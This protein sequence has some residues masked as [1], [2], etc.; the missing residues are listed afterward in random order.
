VKK[1]FLYS[2]VILVFIIVVQSCVPPANN[3]PTAPNNP[4]PINGMIDVPL[5]L[6]LKWDASTDP[7]GDTIKYDVYLSSNPSNMVIKAL[8]CTTNSYEITQPLDYGTKYYWKV[9]AKD[10]KGGETEGT[11]WNFTTKTNNPPSIPSIPDPAD[12]AN[13]VSITPTLSW[14]KCTDPD[15]DI[16][17]YDVLFGEDGQSLTEM[18]TD[19]STNSFKITTPL[20]Y[21]TK[22]LWKV[23]AK[24]DNGGQSQGEIWIFTTGSELNTPPII[25]NN[26]TPMDKAGNVGIVPVISWNSTDPDGDTLTYDI[27]FGTDP[28]PTLVQSNY[29]DTKYNPGVLSYNTTYYWKIVAK[30]G[31]GGVTEGS[32][33]S[34]R[35]ILKSNTPPA[36]PS[37]PTPAHGKTGLDI[38]TIFS[39]KCSDPDGD[40]LIYDIYFGTSSTPTLVKSDYIDTKYYPGE[41][42]YSTRYYWKIVAKDGKGGETSSPVWSF[43]TMAKPNTP[44]QK[45]NNPTPADKA[46]DTSITPTLSWQCSD[47]DGDGLTYDIYF[48]S[49][50]TLSTAVKVGHTSTSY[51]P[52]TLEYSTTYYWKIVAKDG[53][54]G[55]KEGD[56]WSFTTIAKPNTP[57]TKPSVLSP[58]NGENGVSVTQ[59]LSWTSSDADGDSL[60]YDVYFGTSATPT[61]VSSNQEDATYAPTKMSYNTTYYWKVIAIDGKGGIT[62][63]DVW[64]FKT[65]P[66]PNTP[67]AIPSNQKPA[68]GEINV[69]TNPTLSWQCSDPD[70]D[71]ITYDVYFGTSATLAAPV[72]VGQS[73]AT[74]TPNVLNYS[75]RYYWKIVAKDGKGGETSGAVWSFV[76]MAKPNTPPQVPNNPTPADNATDTS[77]TPTLSWVCSDVDGDTLMYDIYFGKNPSSL[78]RVKQDQT[79]ATYN[80]GVLDYNKTYYWKIVAKD[81]KG[82]EVPSS[83]WNFTTIPEPNTAPTKPRNPVPANG[84][85]DIDIKSPT[86]SWLCNDPDGDTLTYDIYFGTDPNPAIKVNN[87]E[88]TTYNPGALSYNTTYYWKVVARDRKGGI[89]EG[90][91]W[92]FKTG[93]EPNTA[94]A[95]PS[96]PNPADNANGTGITPTLSW[97]SSDPDGDGL[98]YDVYFGT[99]PDPDSVKVGQI[100]SSYNPGV[101]NYSTRYYWKIVA[102]DGKGGEASSPVWSFVTM[103]KPNTP[104]QKPNNPIP[105]DK[106]VDISITPTLSWQCS[107]V[108]G[109]GLTYDVYFGIDQAPAL[110]A[111]DQ[112]V[113][114]YNPG[115]LDYNKTYYWKVV[116]KDGKGGTNEGDV[117]SFTTIAK[118]N[119]PP[120]KPSVLSPANGE[121]GVSVTQKLSWTSSDADGDSLKYD[122]YFGTSATPTLVSSNQEDATYAPTKMS[123]N[124][125]YYWKVIAIDGKGGIT[126]GDV[127]S[128]KTGPEPNTPPA[129]PSNQKPADGE[130][131]VS[132]NPTL[133]W[134]C[135]DPD[136]DP[137]TYDVYFGTSA[138]LAAPVKVGQSEATY[139]PNVLNYSTR[140][141]WKIVAKDGKGGETSG[142]VWSFVTMAKPNTPPQVPNN[143]TPAD[144]ATDTSITPTLSWVCSDV[145]GDT[146][147][148]D[149]YFG[150]NPSSLT[151]VK[152]D[153]TNATYNPGVLDYNKTYYW[154][155]VAKDGKG[156]EVP[157]SVWNFTTIPEPNTAPT[158]PRN[159][160]PANGS[161]DIDIKSPTLSWLCNDPDGDTLTYD[162]YFGTD[163][164][165]A[166]KVNNQEGTTYNPGALSYN[167]TYY[168]KVVARDRK[169]G[170]TEGD[171]WSFKTGVE[172]NAAPAI[173]SNPTPAN[174][175]TNVEITPTLSWQCSDPDGDGLTYDVYFGT[176]PEPDS[177]KVGQ[178][179]S[180]YNP[181]ILNYSTRYYW[182]IVAKDGKGGE[183][184]SP[185]WS[186]VTMAKPNT[187]PQKPNNP[188]PADKAVDTSITPKLSWVCSDVDGDTLMYDVYFGTSSSSLTRVKQDQTNATYNPGVLNYSTTYYWKIVAKDGK[189]GTNEGDVW[190]FTT[191]AKPN[192]PP[193]SPV[194]INP[195]NGAKDVK[196]TS[197]LT[198]TC[199]DP[200]G[201]VLVYDVYFGT[202]AT[203]T[204][205]S[206]N[207]ADTSYNPGPM[208][209]STT[210]YWKIVAKDPR[211]GIKEGSVWSF[212]TGAE[213]NNPPQVPSNPDPVNRAIGV[214]DTPTLSWQC[215]DPDGDSLTY[216][217]YF[218]TSTNPPL[219][220]S[221]L[222]NTI[223]DPGILNYSTTYYWKVVAKDGKGGITQGSVWSFTTIM[224]PGAINWQ[225]VTDNVI[226]SSPALGI[227]GTIYIGSWDQKL[228][229]IYPNG[230]KKWEFTTNG[231]VVS[232]A[233]I[234]GNGIIYVG[235]EDGNLYAI[236]PDGTKKWEFT[237]DGRITSSPAISKNG[238]VYVGC[239]DG[240]LY[241]INPNGT[242]KWKFTTGGSIKSSPTI[243]ANGVVYV[244][245]EDGNLYAINPNGSEKW[246]FDAESPIYSGPA[247]GS[248]G[249][250]YVAAFNGTLYAINPAG[251]TEK[252]SYTMGSYVESSPAIGSDGT[253]YIGSYDYKL[254]AINPNNT[255]KWTF[256]TNRQITSTPAIGS[257]G[258]IYVGSSD[259]NLYAIDAT[260]AKKWEAFIGGCA[261]SSPSIASDGTVYIG[262]LDGKLYAIK[263]DSLGL[264][265]SPW[266][267]FMKNLRNTGNV[268]DQ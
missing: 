95:V 207:Q 34:F 222:E 94:P 91:V 267:K 168:W 97:T 139:T 153:Q 215:I 210:Y 20:K 181:G 160:V 54:E 120:T 205:V 261:Y 82:G 137:I 100:D 78:T 131:N 65:G 169:G 197:T 11:V 58:A 264:A 106:A 195:A 152:Q 98:T 201:D 202:S 150:K 21:E 30:D 32:I 239:D 176:N 88:G 211:G 17:K 228:Y 268:L 144:N 232:S 230:T 263:S 266:P 16:V 46:V 178:T 183:T 134:Q 118:P 107:D 99:N 146:L 255:L 23:I 157:S 217:V 9:V 76:T 173:P 69:S 167:T 204:L 52:G 172:P 141:Y 179:N 127:W 218:G 259:G 3:P 214:S 238:V 14:G 185:V 216:D 67:P 248:D 249:T 147:M 170:I 86:L 22:Y 189:E 12:N 55:T 256:P 93:V 188:T 124:T 243:D 104:P 44:P 133:S 229:A 111:S 61:L 10:G 59:K 37:D 24:D 112:A 28:T 219:V 241:A 51:N 231:G 1:V 199:D 140:Y 105:A 190:S 213:P 89:T 90:D 260:G 224:R 87:Q 121:N 29:T 192:T 81:G 174:G 220:K 108:D 71:P 165:P 148:Y 129:I 132:T 125:T 184:S 26:P 123:Y 110:K 101:L 244:G 251:G 154:K 253:I 33:W 56:V 43:V 191:I 250:I 92:S 245:S 8:D 77:I 74:Y 175:L 177:V 79:N 70:G 115:V 162:I 258:I 161:T 15:G 40:E 242:Q 221:D 171:V 234:D 252:W 64:S 48:A 84:S 186:F 194:N 126:E 257:D 57:P 80:P 180:S 25:S 27:Y 66:E 159:P 187:P 262:S 182:K 225:F 62:E 247:I 36:I 142:A 265:N 166:I 103:A 7:D 193:L 122:V 208:N 38:T 254:Y 236:N 47:V 5:T 45:P 155:I 135:S 145:D 85:T 31:K 19:L 73:E 151:R 116:A 72:K 53:K 35:T 2:F 119:T 149:I 83:V 206:S 237:A 203:P 63:G 6:T 128:F 113:A 109:D 138:T 233:A 49:N 114:T 240:S 163:P 102:K 96:N 68:D 223:Y 39:W 158:K 226:H 4:V 117:W 18:A 42:N 60:K 212:T 246:R 75:T 41:L 198:W 143:P 130:I 227:D 235:S 200:D 156:G 209:Y 196:T 50:T 164:N 136:G 13:N